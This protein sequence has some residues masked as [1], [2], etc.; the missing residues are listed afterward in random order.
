VI[1]VKDTEV[2]R[3]NFGFEN[4]YSE[5]NFDDYKEFGPFTFEKNKYSRVIKLLKRAH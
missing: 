3:S 2:T 1:E 4:G 5:P